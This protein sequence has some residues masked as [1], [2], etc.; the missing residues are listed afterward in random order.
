MNDTTDIPDKT[1]L[2][3]QQLYLTNEKIKQE[4]KKL[5]KDSAPDKW[6]SSIVKNIVAIGGIVTVAATSYGLWDSYDKTIVDR[7]NARSTEQHTQLE[8][9]ITRLE[10]TSTISKLIGVSVLSDYL[11]ARNPSF[12]H[13][14]LFTV[15]SLVATE[16]DL[17]TQTAVADMISAVPTANIS[18]DDWQY[19][20]DIL[21]SQSRALMK[22]GELYKHRQFGI[23]D[24]KSSSEERSAR[25]VS[26]LI[27]N[28]IRTNVA[29]GYLNYSGIYCEYCDFHDVTFPKGTNFSGAVL[30]HANFRNASLEGALFDNADLGDANFSQAYLSGAKFRSLSLTNASDQD[31]TPQMTA[32]PYIGHISSLLETRASIIIRLPNFSCA[33]LE[34][35]RFDNNALFPTAP[36]AQRQFAKGD[37]AKPGWPKTV[38]DFVKQRANNKSPTQFSVAVAHPVKFYKANLRGAQLGLARYFG[39]SDRDGDGENG[40]YR[41]LVVK[42]AEFDIL[43]GDLSDDTLKIEPAKAEGEKSGK[44]DTDSDSSI[45][46]AQR[47]RLHVQELL[48]ASFYLATIDQAVLPPGIADFLKTSPPQEVDYRRA[49]RNFPGNTDPDLK[50]T[51]R[52]APANSGSATAEKSET[53]Q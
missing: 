36:M 32:T 23:D 25:F 11:S 3:R 1:E 22:K 2:E 28:N 6:W 19:F 20:Q 50:C 8:E 14:V 4:T 26:K 5:E 37:D 24:I 16:Q 44:P 41:A 48:K 38:S 29:P 51:T 12:H 18:G 9:A 17:Q 10:S 46:A 39:I 52:A 30:D 43:Q 33:N 7:K 35:A 45:G 49:F 31:D 47:D 21:A 13:Q 42:A 27:L 53:R 34:N 40:I 15:A